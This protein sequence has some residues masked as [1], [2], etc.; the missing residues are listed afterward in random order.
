MKKVTY[1]T[2]F[3]FLFACYLNAQNQETDKT[4]EIFGFV[5][6]DSG[7]DFGR[8]NPY[9]Y[10]TMR[11][12]KILD[13]QGQEFQSQGNYYMGI[14]QTTLGIKN[15]FD[16]SLGEVKTYIEI[17][18]LGTGKEA[19][20]TAI[21]IRHVYAELGKLGIGQTN[22][23]F[24]DMEV[25]PKIIEFMGPNAMS[26]YRN[27]QIRYTPILN[28]NQRLAIALERPG[29]TADQGQYGEEFIY[30]A[31]L[32]DVTFRFPLPDLSAE[33]RYSSSWGYIELAGILRTIKWEDHNLDQFN[34]SGGTTGWGLSLSTRLKLGKNVIYHGAFTGGA[35][36]QNYMNDAEASIGIKRQYNNALI[37]ITGV[38]IPMI[39]IVSY[40]DIYWDRNFSTAIGYSIM[41]NK[42]TEAQLATAYKTG[43]YASINLLYSPAKNCILGSELQWGKRQ[44]NDF[45][46]DPYFNLPAEKGNS[47][48]DLKL[49]FSFKY[50]FNTTFYKSK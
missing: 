24:S 36:I 15:Y 8:I 30:A 13:K 11:P 12:T 34:L 10:D 9:W 2:L 35:G 6:L 23:L 48:T 28:N 21:R 49:Q 38:A 31:V 39:G 25:F 50:A 1:S 14:R 5:M 46:G 41:N 20:N 44:N 22:S 45:G 27:I 43:Q 40:F 19:G 37:P 7:Y 18:L 32:D 42:T 17:D 4:M 3:V 33:Y 47:G 26:A 29:A 16:I